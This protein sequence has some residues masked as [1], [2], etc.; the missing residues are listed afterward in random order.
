MVTIRSTKRIIWLSALAL[1]FLR[2][3]GASGQD[4]A[5]EAL[6]QEGKTQIAQG[7]LDAGC[8]TFA[9]ALELLK[10]PR[11]R[12]NLADCREKQG[13]FA[14]AWVEY[15]E[16]RRMSNNLVEQ[17][18]SEAKRIEYI[19]EKIKAIEP[20]ISYLIVNVTSKVPGLE[21]FR[22]SVLTPEGVKVP[23]DPG[24]YTLIAKA[25]GYV[26]WS[27]SFK[28]EGEGNTQTLKVPPLK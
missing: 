18:P 28:V 22:D 5:A 7:K 2:E 16:T 27:Q 25:P 6:L 14:S 15:I 9:K 10:H 26:Q 3:Q 21:I 17:E 23:V 19:N 24:S 8:T 11:I 20:K 1:F 12:I 13:K 4:A